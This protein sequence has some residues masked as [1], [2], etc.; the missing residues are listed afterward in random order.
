MIE[1]AFVARPSHQIQQRC[2]G[3]IA[4]ASADGESNKRLSSMEAK[5]AEIL[6]VGAMSQQGTNLVKSEWRP[7][8]GEAFKQGIFPNVPK[9]IT[10]DAT[11]TL[12]QLK[13]DVGLIYRNT[14]HEATR[15]RA[16]L[17]TPATFTTAFNKAFVEI[18]EQ[19]PCY[20]CGLGMTSREWWYMVSKK[21]FDYVEN[22]DY[23][24]G[25]RRRL[26]GDLG[27]AV[28]EVLYNSVFQ[29]SEAW[30]LKPGVLEALSRFKMWRDEGGPVLA[31]LANHDERLHKILENLGID[32]AFD[33][34]LTSRE[35]G[36]AKPNRSA[37][38]VA[39]SRAGISD[40]SLC[41]HIGDG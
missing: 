32:G 7:P 26:E 13:S 12:I 6:Q 21:T 33:F 24:S 39:M 14:L 31:V 1:G 4:N 27:D 16:R 23:E 25:L 38:E 11:D 36:S 15:F 28:C 29:G 18:N 30:E 8:Q 37:Y 20:G 9:L 5:D 22:I 3:I 40:A 17:P 2:T 35:I 10:M 19:Y 41:M 34:V